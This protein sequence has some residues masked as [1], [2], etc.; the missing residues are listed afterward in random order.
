MRSEKE[1]RNWIEGIEASLRATAGGYGSPNEQRIRLQGLK[2]AL[3][4]VLTETV[5]PQM[6]LDQ[7]ELRD[8]RAIL[9]EH[10]KKSPS[11]GMKPGSAS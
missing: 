5:E 8:L 11:L 3:Q 1:I 4:W 9:A 7:I 2:E 6:P 10:R